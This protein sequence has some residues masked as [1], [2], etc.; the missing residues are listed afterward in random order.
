MNKYTKLS[1]KEL[2]NSNDKF[3][4]IFEDDKKNIFPIFTNENTFK[5]LEEINNDNVYKNNYLVDIIYEL[6][7][8]KSIFISTKENESYYLSFKDE[9]R[10]LDFRDLLILSIRYNIP[11]N[12]VSLENEET[13]EY[14]DIDLYGLKSVKFEKF[15][16]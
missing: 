6:E 1:F 8:P 12:L 13:K 10:I 2:I 4:I 3:L 7:K 16:H 5:F 11:L 14:S 9:K 15:K